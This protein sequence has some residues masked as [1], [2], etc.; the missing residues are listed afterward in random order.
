MKTY[1]YEEVGYE[2]KGMVFS[3]TEEHREIIDRYAKK[4]YRFAG[5]VP[6]EVGAGGCWRKIDLIFEKEG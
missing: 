2:A 6:T 4:G 1:E 5:A 3:H